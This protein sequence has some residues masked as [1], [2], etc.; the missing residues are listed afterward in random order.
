MN[1][2]YLSPHLDDVALS[3]GG[4]LWSQSQQGENVAVW[5]IC[6]GD[7][8]AGDL[9][10]FAEQL[11]ARWGVGRSAVAV[12]RKE[13]RVACDR[14]GAAHKHFSIPDCIYRRAPASREHLYASESAIFGPVHPDEMV[15]LAELSDSIGK[16]LPPHSQLVCPLALG[17]HV[18]H[19]MTRAAAEALG[20][21]LWY[22]ADYPYV[23][24]SA[25]EIP[26]LLPQG[27]QMQIFPLSEP[28]E[29]AWVGSV[30]AHQSQI[31]TFWSDL[32]A[33][34]AA[35]RAYSLSVGGV[36]LWSPPLKSE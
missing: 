2:V 19:R 25:G 5:T 8:P 6:A 29:Q 9:S 17:G 11:H 22:Y 23:Q 31:S 3:C 14:L 12:R 36:R 34:E 21:P 13:D 15:L 35:I 33:M 7:P 28:A 4:L 32:S 24:R 18:D 20:V 26:H 10:D 30:A 1:W 27:W 16:Q